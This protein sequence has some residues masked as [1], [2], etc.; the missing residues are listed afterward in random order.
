MTSRLRH[1]A[2][3]YHSVQFTWDD[4]TYLSLSAPVGMEL[5]AER[6]DHDDP[7]GA[8]VIAALSKRFHALHSGKW[9]W[10]TVSFDV[11]KRDGDIGFHVDGLQN[12]RF[13]RQLEAARQV[14][15][16]AAFGIP[17]RVSDRDL[18]ELLGTGYGAL[19]ACPRGD[20]MTPKF[21]EK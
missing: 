15:L 6:S 12:S 14:V 18:A 13:D 10:D 16:E 19:E 8:V 5:L 7:H 1:S 2:H 9:K 11:H 21:T 17:P 20:H 3:P 4:G